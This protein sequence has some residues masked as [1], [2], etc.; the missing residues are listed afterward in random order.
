MTYDKPGPNM[1]V[2]VEGLQGLLADN[3]IGMQMEEEVNS[4]ADMVKAEKMDEARAAYLRIVEKIGELIFSR[5]AD[6]TTENGSADDLVTMLEGVL[7]NP[8]EY[9]A[10]T[11]PVFR[12]IPRAGGL[13][14]F[15]TQFYK[16]YHHL[17][18]V[19]QPAVG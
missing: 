10:D 3:F 19:Q 17:S 18:Q 13:R 8:D 11:S 2:V 12:A 1:A 4:L 6:F 7:K 14:D 9:D 5:P 15:I 16:A